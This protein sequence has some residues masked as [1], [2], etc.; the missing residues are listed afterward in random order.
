[1]KI[2]KEITKELI[3]HARKDAP[4]EACGYLAGKDNIIT[5]HYELTNT[6]KSN[7][8]FSFD[9]SEQFKVVKDA[10]EKGLEI[11]GVY[12]SHPAT[13]ARPS[14]EDIKLAYDPDIIY[15]IVSLA[16]VEEEI[17]AFSIKKGEVEEI[18]LET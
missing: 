12:H 13:P 10:R 1:M 5:R 8:H 17:K 11:Y 4:V 2:S 16:G 15:V 6:D 3:T 7:E 14:A 18:R 9:P